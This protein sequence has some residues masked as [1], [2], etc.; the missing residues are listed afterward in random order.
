MGKLALVLG[1]ALAIGASYHYYPKTTTHVGHKI[2][3]T[4]TAAAKAG[5]QAATAS[6]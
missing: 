2:V 4:T 3:H 6:K 5:Y 1:I